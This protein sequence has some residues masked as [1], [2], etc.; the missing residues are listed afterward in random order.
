ME[1][2]LRVVCSDCGWLGVRFIWLFPVR[3]VQ[4]DLRGFPGFGGRFSVVLLAWLVSLL[5]FGALSC[6]GL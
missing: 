3:F 2:R 4:Y 1:L 5:I 6:W